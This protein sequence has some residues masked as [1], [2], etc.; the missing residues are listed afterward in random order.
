MAVLESIRKK[1]GI[2]VSVVIGLALVAF[3]LGDFLGGRGGGNVRNLDIAKVSG[4]TLSL[5]D[6][7]QKITELTNI[8]KR[9][10]Q[11]SSLDE[12]TMDMIHE[13]AWQMM[14]NE[15]ITNEEY[16]Q[17]GLTVSPEELF[18]LISG[19]NPHPVIRQ[20]FTDP[21]TGEFNR[22]ALINFLK[23]KDANPEQSHIWSTIEKDLLRERYAQKY[24][25]LV[26]TGLY[27]PAFFIADENN[28]VNR[29]VSF[30][31]AVKQYSTIPDS[32]VTITSADIK[33][34]YNDHKYQWEQ[35]ASRDIDYVVF[36]VV[37]SE[38]DRQ[39]ANEWMDKM[40]LEFEHTTNDHQFLTINSDAPFD[41]HFLK[42]GQLPVQAAEL[43]NASVGAMVGPYQEGE[44]LKLIKLLKV[45][46]RPDSVKV[47]QIALTV[48]QTQEQLTRT[49]A[50]ADSIKK[51][52]E[53]GAN[54]ATLAA[55][56]SI[57]P[58]AKT[59]G[60]D[61]GWIRENEMQVRSMEEAL[62]NL[63]KGEV[64][65]METGQGFFIAQ[66]SDWGKTVK[67]VQIATLQHDII[68]S[69]KTEQIIS[70]QANK[71]AAENRTETAFNEAATT[72]HLVKRTAS[73][74]GEN[75]RQI[76]GLPSARSVVRWAY[77]AKKG[78]VSDVMN[79]NDAYVIAVLKTIRKEGIAPVEQV[80]PEISIT[81]RKQKKA[82]QIAA[83]FTEITKTAQSFSEAASKLQL[84]IAN[85]ADVS[86]SAF[87]IPGIG[88]ENAVIATATTI[89]EGNISEPVEG[90]NGVYLLTVT[91]IV[92]AGENTLEQIKTRLTATYNNRAMSEPLQAL[93]KAAGIKD[94]RSKFY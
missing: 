94:L 18:D 67:K 68:A 78:A 66:V 15:E 1:G 52:L 64:T 37:P 65:I 28:D 50:V 39:M 9:D 88:V 87:S 34:Y 86:F 19:S 70:T 8:Y 43:Y 47:N 12:R 58:D 55:K 71:F 32:T 35:T 14:I 73:Y 48:P 4:R 83:G 80:A 30:D 6:Y 21:Q 54:F 57:M 36:N 33:K 16:H 41:S 89:G 38:E 59:T 72:Q 13:Q 40:K 20:N 53:G 77:G 11:Q 56:Y 60:G 29:K 82:E 49:K 5:P 2:I 7:E 10:T 46:N 90:S 79:L 3:I 75:D 62:F 45:E 74:I 51:A 27:V 17:I 44:S 84:P 91:Q 61:V 22:S 25:T 81:L 31:Y 24:Q 93:R 76:V 92:A 63:K 69:T 26:S 23:N 42:E 85:A